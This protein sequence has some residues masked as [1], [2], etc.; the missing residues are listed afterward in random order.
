MIWHEDEPISWPS[1]VSLYHVSHSPRKSK[2]VL[3][4]EGSDELF[5]GYGRYRYQLMSQAQMNDLRPWCR[6]ALRSFMRGADRRFA[7]CLAATCAASCSTPFWAARCD[8]QSLYLENFYGAFPAKEVEA[9]SLGLAIDPGAA[10]ATFIRISIAS[11]SCPIWNGC[12]T[13]IRKPIWWNC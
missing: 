2:V 4:G 8:L 11:R 10:Y 13:P 6:R 12:S 3:T 5:A 1:S 7:R 9:A